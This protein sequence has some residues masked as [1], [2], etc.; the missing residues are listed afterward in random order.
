MAESNPSQ[1]QT[2]LQKVV[3]DIFDIPE[4]TTKD[5]YARALLDS[6][7]GYVVHEPENGQTVPKNPDDIPSPFTIEARHRIPIEDQADYGISLS[8]KNAVRFL[9]DQGRRKI[10]S[11]TELE[12]SR[13]NRAFG[14]R[15][16]AKTGKALVFTY[17]EILY[18]TN[19]PRLVVI[20]NDLKG[21]LNG[22]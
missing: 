17:A 3:A 8:K 10:N 18:M 6:L 16:L 21:Y 19:H 9:R 13:Y 4:A 5:L 20:P 2:F 12:G 14:R 15:K 22:N 7:S 1:E 11:K